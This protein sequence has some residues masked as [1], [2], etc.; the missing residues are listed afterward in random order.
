MGG[1]LQRVRAAARGAVV[2]DQRAQLAAVVGDVGLILGQRASAAA[3]EQRLVADHPAGDSINSVTAQLGDELGCG[4]AVAVLV[5]TVEG[6]VAERRIAVAA[7]VQIAVPDAVW[8][9]PAGAENSVGKVALGP[10]RLAARDRRVQL[11]DR[12]RRPADRLARR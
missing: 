2:V 7:Q 1:E 8:F 4:R 11:L 5:D 9:E 3:V 6:P 10:S 12:C